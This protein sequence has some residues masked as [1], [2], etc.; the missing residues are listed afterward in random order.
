MDDQGCRD[1]AAAVIALAAKEWRN[2]SGRATGGTRGPIRRWIDAP[3]NLFLAIADV[4]P[5]SLLEE[6]EG[7]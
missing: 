2:V 7:E 4:N 6:L 5:E 1:L 3:D